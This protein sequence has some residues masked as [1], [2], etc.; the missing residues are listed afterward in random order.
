MPLRQPHIGLRKSRRAAADMCVRVPPRLLAGFARVANGKSQLIEQATLT[1]KDV[2]I[3]CVPRYLSTKKQVCESQQDAIPIAIVSAGV[4]PKVFCARGGKSFRR[5][6]AG[7]LSSSTACICKFERGHQTLSAYK[8][9]QL[10]A[11]VGYVTTV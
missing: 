1:P 2:E 11:C 9:Q 10:L 5:K 8:H 6:P 3:V 7:Q 4:E